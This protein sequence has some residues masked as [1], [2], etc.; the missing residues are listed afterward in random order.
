M[1]V[2]AQPR[3]ADLPSYLRGSWS[4]QTVTFGERNATISLPEGWSIRD[5]G[6]SVS[7]AEAAADC[8]IDFL[9]MPGENEQR[10]ARELAEDRKTSQYAMHSVLSRAG[11]VRVVSVRYANGPER[12]VEKRYFELPSDE[13]G[14][15]LEWTLNAQ[16][17]ND[18]NDCARR[19][20]VVAGSFSLVKTPVK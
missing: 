3:Q 16:S 20:N 2:H 13:G 17:T 6:I 15:L 11:G 10:L 7:D 12:F 8:H 18:G 4:K 9:L 5:G 1:A 14:T 19:F